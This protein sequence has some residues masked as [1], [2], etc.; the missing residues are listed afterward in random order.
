VT[1]AL[2]SASA[3]HRTPYGDAEVRWRRVRGRVEVHVV[4]PVGVTAHVY[5]PSAQA[6]KTVTHGQHVWSVP[7]YVDHSAGLR[8]PRTVRELLDDEEAWKAVVSTAAAFGVD[9]LTAARRLAPHLDAPVE[10]LPH[11]FTIDEWAQGA[12][13]LR[14]R[15]TETLLAITDAR[16]RTDAVER[17]DRVTPT[18]LRAAR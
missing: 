17:L 15:L 1:T 18:G 11:L 12:L 6:P 7:D 4:V 13:S 14:R 9:D 10:R 16:K 8:T 5:L 2:S 3:R